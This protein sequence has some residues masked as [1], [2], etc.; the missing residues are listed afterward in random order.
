MNNTNNDLTETTTMEELKME[1]LK[2]E[3]LKMKDF[4]MEELKRAVTSITMPKQT[5]QDL[6][7]GCL[8]QNRT[9]SQRFRYPKWIAAALAIVLFTAVG[10]TSYAAY[11]LYQT[12]NL[13]VFFDY[14]ITEDQINAIGKELNAMPGIY[15]LHFTS[16]DEAWEELRLEYLPEEIAMQFTENPLKDSSNYTVTVKLDADT[17]AIREQIAKL[18]GVR[19]VNDRNELREA[20]KMT[21]V[22]IE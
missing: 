7:E 13:T 6:L 3:E 2:M 17:T 19:L 10:T 21:A 9:A 11:N 16:S 12:K 18:D 4:K 22:S 8:S 20:E 15:S 1:E 5:A 14:G